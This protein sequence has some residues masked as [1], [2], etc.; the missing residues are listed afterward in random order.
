MLLLYELKRAKFQ[1]TPPVW[2]V[3]DIYTHITEQHKISIHTTRVGGDFLSFRSICRSDI[4]IHTTR[5]GG[6]M[7][8]KEQWQNITL[9]SIHT[10]RVGGDAL[11]DIPKAKT[12]II[13]IHTTR[14]GGDLFLLLSIFCFYNFNPH[15]P[16]GW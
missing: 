11:K 14:V 4:S 1:S 10:T 9:I 12:L 6:D 8:K 5:V 15:H 13:S 16:C 2:V 3:T 7:H